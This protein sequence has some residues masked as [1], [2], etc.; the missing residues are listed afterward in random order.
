M[1]CG[2][3]KEGNE[4]AS[5][6]QQQPVVSSSAPAAVVTGTLIRRPTEN[7]VPE[8]T[9]RFFSKLDKN[10]DNR[11]SLAELQSGFEAEFKGQLPEHA[12]AAIVELFEAHAVQEE[13]MLSGGKSLAPA[14]FNRFYAEIL[15][16]RFDANDNGVLELSEATEAL[17]F[18][19]KTKDGVKPDVTVGFPK[20]FYDD[21]GDL[22]LPKRWF[23]QMYQGME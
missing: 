8:R 5:T 10:K 6:Q 1:G 23:F 12:K 17:K 20:D 16:R 11:V 15:F 14:A 7:R 3:S 13:G 21:K 19:K 2:G 4:G 22:K 18:L 9:K